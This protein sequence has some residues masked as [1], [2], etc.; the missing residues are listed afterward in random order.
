MST[1]LI[2]NKDD[3]PL[4]RFLNETTGSNSANSLPAPSSLAIFLED[5]CRF[6]ATVCTAKSYLCDISLLRNCFGPICPALA[7]RRQAKRSRPTDHRDN[8][9]TPS[10][11]PARSLDEITT[12]RMEA[13]LCHKIHQH[14]ISNQ[15]A[16]RY[17]EIL[18]RMLA[19]AIRTGRLIP[20]NP[21][22]PNPAAAVKKRREPAPTIR[23][24]TL[25]QIDRQLDL[26]KPY[27]LLYALVATYIYAGLRRQE[28]LWLTLSDIDLQ[29]R[30][31]TIRAKTVHGQFWQ[32]KTKRNRVV[33]ISSVLAEIFASYQPPSSV[34]LFLSPRGRCWHPDNFSAKL[35]HLN[36]QHDLAWSCLD[37]RH[38]FG[39]QLAQKGESVY[40]IAALMGN[41]PAICQRHYAVLIP[42]KMHDVVEF[43]R[44][45]PN[46]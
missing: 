36:R 21:Y 22:S 8:A 44:S 26:L 13:F 31:I 15:T 5:Y 12:A 2:D 37:Y 28:A 27:P 25:A 35:R 43:S 3:L 6:L 46:P 41:S 17:R 38:T 18:H 7:Y 1:C 42:E 14:N 24:L 16:N 34:W 4:F 9:S 33:P 32:P 39:S 20:T 19:Y 40:K 29:R 11:I 23:Y 10:W 45:N 30:L